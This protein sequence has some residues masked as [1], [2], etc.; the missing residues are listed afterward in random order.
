MFFI[1]EIPLGIH[2]YYF[3]YFWYIKFQRVTVLLFILLTFDMFCVT[4]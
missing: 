3:L 2:T 4:I 1:T